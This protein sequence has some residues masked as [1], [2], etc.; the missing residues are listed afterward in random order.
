MATR[1]YTGIVTDTIT[2]ETSGDTF[3]V[4]QGALVLRVATDTDLTAGIAENYFLDK[5]VKDNTFNIKGAVIGYEAGMISGGENTHI[6]VG[7]TGTVSGLVAIALGGDDSDLVNDGTI[8]GEGI[9]V[10]A[11]LAS[12]LVIQNNGLM[13]GTAGLFL[14]RTDNAQIVNG[15]TGIIYGTEIGLGTDSDATDTI[16][17]TNH[18][19]IGSFAGFESLLLGAGREIVVNKGRLIGDVSLGAGNDTLDNRGGFIKGLIYGGAGSDT[20]YVDNAKDKLIEASDQGTDRIISSVTYTLS[21][22]VENLVQI[23]ANNVNGTG[24][25]LNNQITGNIG[26]NRLDGRAGDDTLIGGS[27]ADK[28]YGGTGTDRFVFQKA[29]DSFLN[30]RD[31]IYDFSRAEGDKIDLSGVDAIGATSGNEAFTFIGTGPFS[32]TAGELR[33]FKGSHTFIYGDVNGDGAI[34]FTICLDR[35]IDLTSTDFIL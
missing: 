11:T 26:S 13:R 2:V 35:T 32:N 20:L 30:A 9:G 18:G 8:T 22:N 6:N 17:I 34:D 28:L 25:A 10:F 23:G 15:V 29:S 21:N 27:G 12:N 33:Y 3:N 24:N 19:T 1:N 31:R 16:R 7:T 14:D 5:P 4:E